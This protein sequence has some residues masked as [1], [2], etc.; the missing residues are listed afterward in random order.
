MPDRFNCKKGDKIEMKKLL[1][2]IILAAVIIEGI[3]G[4]REDSG[5]AVSERSAVSLA[6]VSDEERPYTCPRCG[7]AGMCPVC[8]GEGTYY[9]RIRGE[10]RPCS[11]CRD[12]PG[13]CQTC[14]GY[15]TVT[16]SN[17]QRVDALENSRRSDNTPCAACGGSGYGSSPCSLC[18]G[19]G[20]N[21]T[22]ERTKGSALHGFADKDCPKCGG[23]GMSKCTSCWGT[24][25]E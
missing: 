13:V 8:D 22:Y 21:S 4:I 12:N 14:D 9:N 15:G 25:V 19:T 2:I 23:T 11:V 6:A 5:D 10:E 16:T 7:G 24:G 1:L 17:Y 3:K 18:N 20:I